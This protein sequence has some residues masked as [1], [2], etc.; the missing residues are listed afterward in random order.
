MESL[1][2]RVYRI[3]IKK[4]SKY[5]YFVKYYIFN[6]FEFRSYKTNGVIL[7]RLDL[8]GD[9]TMFTSS[10]LAIRNMYKNVP[11]TVV[12]LKSCKH[13]DEI[14]TVDFRPEA[15]DYD[16]LE[17]VIK[18]IRKKEYDV[19]LQPQ[20]SKFPLAD[21]LAIATKCNKRISIDTK[22][23]N[24]T[25]KWINFA[26]RIYDKLISYTKNS[27]VSEFQYYGEFIR[28]LGYRDFKTSK[29][30]LSYNNQNFITDKYYI[31]YPCGSVSWKWWPAER[32]AEVIDYIYK[33]TGYIGVVL[34]VD[35]EKEIALEII[36]CSAYGG[37]NIINLMGKTTVND[38]IDLIGNARF[39]ISND[40]SGVHIACATNTPSIAI[41]GGGHYGRF[42]PYGLEKV[43]PEDNL[44]HVAY[45]EMECFNC[46]WHWDII[47]FKNPDCL[48]NILKGKVIPCI[49][50]IKV[51]EVVRLVDLILEKE[52]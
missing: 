40:T 39:V 36:K 51:S 9:C 38:V 44:P 18:K 17:K 47:N 27:V 23:D 29:P 1:L 12:C 33:K 31:I 8:M 20:L 28:G 5:Y 42:L 30:V 6:K 45:S 16:S 48:N 35:T 4:Q 10:A 49:E 24:S 14:I 37:D 13:I 25:E 46:D 43:N 19:L 32:Y 52:N 11:M 15:I 26:N 7:F 2:E 50:K 34:G 3:L 41:I 21:I 22:P